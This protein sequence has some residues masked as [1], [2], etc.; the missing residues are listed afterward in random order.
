MTHRT[1]G[2]WSATVIGS[3]VEEAEVVSLTRGDVH[4][5]IDGEGLGVRVG[6][7]CTLD[8]SPVPGTSDGEG[9]PSAMDIRTRTEGAL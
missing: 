9:P 5:V 3:D 1:G 6:R 8:H 2:S 7:F 4:I